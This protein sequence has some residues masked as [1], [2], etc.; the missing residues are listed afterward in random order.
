[1]PEIVLWRPGTNLAPLSLFARVVYKI[2]FTR[3]DFPEPLTPVT[4]TNTPRGTST[5]KS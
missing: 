3:V 4:D 1:M 5:S 2:S